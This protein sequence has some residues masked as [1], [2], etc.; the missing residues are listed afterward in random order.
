VQRQ[1]VAI[2]CTFCKSI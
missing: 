1:V 2:I